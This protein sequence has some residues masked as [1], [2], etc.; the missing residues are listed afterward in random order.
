MNLSV[1]LGWHLST[2]FWTPDPTFRGQQKELGYLVMDRMYKVHLRSG[3]TLIPNRRL[4]HGASRG[5][6]PFIV[7]VLGLIGDDGI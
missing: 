2:S 6:H 3:L 1:L 4:R 7:I 5:E